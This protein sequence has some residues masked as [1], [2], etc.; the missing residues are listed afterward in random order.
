M[1]L[2]IGFVT[3]IASALPRT[4]IAAWFIFI[5]CSAIGGRLMLVRIFQ[6]LTARGVLCDR[7]AVLGS[8]EF[9]E[10]VVAQVAG[11]AATGFV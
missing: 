11:G 8:G 7:V 2:A 3:E 10:A 1:M 9:A 5:F 4:W 6:R